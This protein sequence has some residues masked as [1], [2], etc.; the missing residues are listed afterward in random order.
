MLTLKPDE[1]E[2]V[3]ASLCGQR[4]VDE[5]TYSSVAV[6]AER[7]D[8]LKRKSSLFSAVTFSSEAEQL[9]VGQPV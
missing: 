3:R 1:T 7:L 5:K 2:I 9:A 4:H 6:L 8:R